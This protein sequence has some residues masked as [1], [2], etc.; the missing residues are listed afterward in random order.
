[1]SFKAGVTGRKTAANFRTSSSWNILFAT[2][3]AYPILE[4]VRKESVAFDI[5]G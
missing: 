4:A 2:A 5:H 3:P 1:M